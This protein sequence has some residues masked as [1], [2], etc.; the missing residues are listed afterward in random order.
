M[1]KLK[2][3]DLEDWIERQIDILIEESIWY[4]L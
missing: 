3:F 2:W 1:T 4:N